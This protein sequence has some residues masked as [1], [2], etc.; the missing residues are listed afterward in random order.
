MEGTWCALRK[1]P[2]LGYPLWDNFKLKKIHTPAL[3]EKSLSN[4]L[5]AFHVGMP[6]YLQLLPPTYH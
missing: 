2:L 4:M 1:R 6:S 5:F 3:N